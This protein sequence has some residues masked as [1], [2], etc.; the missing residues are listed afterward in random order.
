MSTKSFNSSVLDSSTCSAGDS[1]IGSGASC[2]NS[3]VVDSYLIEA[4]RGKTP[5]VFWLQF[6]CFRFLRW[7]P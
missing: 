5:Y 2:F 3:S 1:L 6:F 7:G 4:V